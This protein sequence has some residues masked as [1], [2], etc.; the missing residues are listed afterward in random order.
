M[1][2]KEKIFGERTIT[3]LLLAVICLLGFLLCFR[4]HF[5]IDFTDEAHYLALAKRFSQG[6]RPFREEW[7]PAQIV[8]ILLLPFYHIYTRMTGGNDGIILAFRLCFVFCHTIVSLC[9]FGVL[10]KKEKLEKIPS[11]AAAVLILFYA[12]ANIYNFSYYNIGLMTFLLFLITEGNRSAVRQVIRGILFA[13]SVLCMPYLSLYF[14]LM[15]GCH[16][17]QIRKGKRAW[18]EE[19]WY[20]TG[21]LLC[22]VIFLGF[23]F[24]SGDVSDIFRNVPEILKDPEHQQTIWDSMVS[25]IDFMIHVFYKYLFWPMLG[26]F[27]CIAYYIRDGRRKRVFGNLLKAAAYLLFYIQAVYV[28]TFFEGGIIIALFL[29]AVQISALEQIRERELWKRYGLP[30]LL[31]GCIWMLGSNV[32]QR[33]FNIGCLISCIW[34]VAV[35][36]KDV[37][38]SQ[39][40]WVAAGKAFAL[41][42]TLMILM[43]ISFFD[44]YRDDAVTNL[45]VKLESGAAGGIYTSPGR[46]E[47][48][49]AVLNKLEEYAEEGKVLA[50]A[51]GNPWIYLE[52]EADCGAYA[53][54]YTDF[55]DA[56]NQTYYGWYP[57][58]VPDVIFLLNP[59]YGTWHGWRYSSH[60]SN[61]E[62]KG[63][64]LLEGY[65]AQIAEKEQYIKAEEACGIFYL[66]R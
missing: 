5:G 16:A 58:K 3:Y 12:R 57:E 52:A 35:I 40:K 54:W 45:S 51:G 18:K 15:E 34:A 56:R 9:V 31:Y 27:L 32:G 10:V 28:R 38:V 48:Y 23:C 4:V 14:I 62:G 20:L 26:E 63:T 29:L 46:A 59:D 1:N 66:K 11:F 65:L 64:K 44:I 53:V 8:G 6:D 7:F 21:I 37:R 61:T 13:V 60:G 41:L 47:E 22:A 42:W 30:G 49:E 43:C 36:W 33:V 19:L 24:S 39:K 2:R 17:V 50:V 25:F 55:L